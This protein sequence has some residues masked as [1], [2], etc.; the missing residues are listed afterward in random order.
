[1]FHQDPSHNSLEF[2]FNQ[3]SL[4]KCERARNITVQNKI[5]KYLFGRLDLFFLQ[6][7]K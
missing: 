7:R 4:E 1:M 2:T 3:S 5:V 6:I